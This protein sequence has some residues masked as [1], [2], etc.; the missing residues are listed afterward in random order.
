MRVLHFFKTY[1]PDTFGGVERTIDAI[2]KSTI[3]YGIESEVLSLSKTP[4]A[5]T[6]QRGEHMAHKAMLDLE[7]AS[8]GLSRAVFGMFRELSSNAD[9]V[10]YHFPWPLMDVV[11]L[12]APP[13]KP[14]I[15]TYHSD[16][17]KQ[18]HLLKLYKPLMNRF[19]GSVDRIVATSPNYLATSKVLQRFEDKT[20]VIPLG[21][22]EVDYPS[23]DEND[24]ARWQARFPKPFF[25]FVGVLRYYKGVQVLL[26]AAKQTNVD[27]VIIG[28]G[29]M[30]AELKSYA[31]DNRLANVVF[32]GALSDSDKKALLDLSIGLVFPS[33][34][35][36]EAFGLSL[37]EAA[38]ASKPMISCEIGTGTSFV[39]LDGRTGLV[40]PP[41]DPMALAAA[42]SKLG[43]DREMSQLFGAAAR[44]RY[45]QYFTAERMGKAYAALYQRCSESSL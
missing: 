11:H 33:H 38:M 23:T 4:D 26:E 42:M 44:S 15:V 32:L 43:S 9:I 19:L 29:P 5:S 31:A 16:I 41:N 10:H 20:T 18:R 14:T 24:K 36:S 13:G 30:E 34:L 3:S 45:E 12:L 25:L 8:T 28:E 40:V 1:W 7:I 37:V 39:N 17:V 2:A 22:D 21:L 6:V 35:R 27:I